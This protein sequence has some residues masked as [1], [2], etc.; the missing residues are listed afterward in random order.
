MYVQDEERRR[1]ARELHDDLGQQL[2]GLNMV[3]PRI[4]GS[5][6]SVKMVDTI[7]VTVAESF[8]SFASAAA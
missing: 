8:L 4:P 6:E 5:E 3:L 1:I 7:L 2:A